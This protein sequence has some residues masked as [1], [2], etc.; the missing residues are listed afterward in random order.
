MRDFDYPLRRKRRLAMLLRTI[1]V[2]LR[3]PRPTTFPTLSPDRLPRMQGRV[4]IIRDGRGIPHIYAQN[5]PDLY[6]A[7]GY[8]QGADRFVLLDILRH[9]GAGRLCDLIGNVTM[10]KDSDMFPGRRMIDLDAFVRP[11][12]FEQ[13]SQRDYEALDARPRECLDAFAAGINAALHAMRGVYPP[14]HLLLGPLHPWRPSD[15]LLAARTCAFCVALPPLDVELTFDAARGHLGDDAARRLYPE[16]PWENAPT[17]YPVVEGSE[18]EPPLHL[19]GTGSNNWAVGAARSASGAPIFANDP[20]VPFLPLPTFWYHAHLDCPLYRIQ[21]G[22]ML[23][24][25]IFGFGHN[26]HLAWGVTTAFRDAWDLYR[27]RRQPNDPTLYRQPDGTGRIAKHRENHSVRFGSDVPIEWETCE[28]GILYPG[29]KHHDGIDLALRYAPSD[30]GRFF[31]GYLALAAAKSVDEHRAAL[32][33][34]ND[35]PFDFNHVYAHKDGHIAW[36]QYGRLPKRSQDGLFV[37]DAHDPAAQWDGFRPFK[38]NPKIINPDCAYVASA[39]SLTDPDNY[40]RLTT[41]VHVEP[42]YRQSRI[43]AYLAAGSKHTLDSFAALQSDLGSDYAVALRDVMLKLL[44][45]HCASR[46]DAVGKGWQILKNWNGHFDTDAGGAVLFALT[47][48]EL[49]PR[50]FRP[51]LGVDIAR[52]YLNT[53]R[54][55]PRLQQVMLNPDDPLRSDIEAAAGATFD[56]LLASAFEAAAE[57]AQRICGNDPQRW[58]WGQVQFI[59]L[60]TVLGELPVIGRLF[61]ALEAPFPGDLHTVSP[62]IPMPAS[63]RLRAF[64]GATS[65]F[66]CDLARPD[67]A[68]FAHTSG[69]S[70]DVGSSFYSNLS[71]PWLHFE[72]FRSSLWRPEDVPNPSERVVIEPR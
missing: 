12:D 68:L 50:C 39:N 57:S 63:G 25:P 4:E 70:G 7:L 40:A 41:R 22:L 54:A 17:S 1:A 59:R 10:P 3:G 65:R 37:R 31:S 16:A 56:V 28:H 27:I 33:L 21:G 44:E 72:Y 20:H 47:Q 60:G 29:W 43:A 13:Q 19:S 66:I 49:S 2:L 34:I 51:L 58:R 48:R 26:G 6:A 14:E 45:P 32:E 23:G 38:E 36:E 5:E 55:T 67:E 35:G 53:R 71:A 24:C 69:P 64:G 8:L 18:P 11:L 46:S 61:R 42:G 9:L 15:A 52:R 62:C 30:A